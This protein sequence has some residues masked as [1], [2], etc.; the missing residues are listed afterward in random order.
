MATREEEEVMQ[1]DLTTQIYIVGG[2]LAGV[3]LLVGL[4]VM[5]LALN[6]TSLQEQLTELS[7]PEGGRNTGPRIQDLYKDGQPNKSTTEL[8]RL[9]Y[10]VYTGSQAGHR[11]HHQ[12]G[13]QRSNL[14]EATRR[15]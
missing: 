14:D 8:E 12:H 9:G 4:M 3:L 10:I 6:I 15:F 5:V 1:L 11:P 7:D 13:G 2:T